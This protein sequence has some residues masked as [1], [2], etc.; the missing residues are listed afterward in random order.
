MNDKTTS[1]R[2]TFS[3][4][5]E[6][7]DE[8]TRF[9]NIT[10]DILHTGQNLNK[11]FFDKNVVDDCIESI[12]N[13]PV[14]GFIKYDA[15]RDEKDFNGHEY[16]LTRTEDG[17]EQKYVG[18]CYGVI[19]ESCEPR[20][21]SK[22]CSDGQEREFLQVD[23]LMWT[24]F[25]DSSDIMM[26]DCEKAQS[27]ELEISSIEGYEDDDGIFHFEKFKFDGACILGEGVQ[28]AMVDANVTLNEGQFAIGE[29]AKS[30]K[31]ELDRKFDIFTKL[32][33]E[34][35]EQGGVLNMPQAKKD[36]AQTVMQ[37]IEDVAVMVSQYETVKNFWDE[38]VPRFQLVDIQDE[39]V[40]VTDRSDSY[41]YY[42]FPLSINGDKPEINFAC[43]K[44]KKF[45]YEDYED[46][47]TTAEGLFDLSEH[48]TNVEKEAFEKVEEVEAKLADVENKFA[49]AEEN[50]SK[51]KADYDEI[52]PKYDEY[53]QAEAQREADEISAQKDAKFAEYENVL[54]DND[55]FIALKERK[56][57][58]SIDDIEK[59]CAVMFVKAARSKSGFS[60]DS[61][62][63]AIVGVFSDG[64]DAL[65]GYA[66]TKYGNVR[67]ER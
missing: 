56:D 26:R 5:G 53:V 42:G 58:M 41:R 10:I 20:W 4:N 37:H 51:V 65:D 64:D 11:S 32:V 67:I 46:D 34:Q 15:K 24:K 36:F 12:K 6:I 47:S 66:R 28:P 31:N 17:I 3:V 19:P 2:S 21:T 16:V 1:L 29:F 45:V 14:L 30:V 44:R 25:D 27:M 59:E 8:D 7:S 63:S 49:E 50:Y 35:D 54:S 13:T 57:E 43:G 9:L 60:A 48:A 39:E 18:S 40:I 55:D 61:S 62:A 33:K 22:M 52:K 23:A 38:D